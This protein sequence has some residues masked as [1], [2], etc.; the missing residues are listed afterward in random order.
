V[1]LGVAL[2]HQ[3]SFWNLFSKRRLMVMELGNCVEQRRGKIYG[4]H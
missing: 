3:P 4:R 1:D 2:A